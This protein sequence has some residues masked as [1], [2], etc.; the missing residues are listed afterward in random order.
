MSIYPK[1]AALTLQN[2]DPPT[3]DVFKTTAQWS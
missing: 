2:T 1:C 3:P